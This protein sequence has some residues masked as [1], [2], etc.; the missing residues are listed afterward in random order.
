[1]SEKKVFIV[2]EDVLDDKDL[3]KYVKSLESSVMSVVFGKTGQDDLKLLTDHEL[4]KKKLPD[5]RCVWGNNGNTRDSKL[6]KGAG[7]PNIYLNKEHLE[8]RSSD[9]V[10]DTLRI[11]HNELFYDNGLEK[12]EVLPIVRKLDRPIYKPN[13]TIDGPALVEMGS[14]VSI[15]IFSIHDFKGVKSR[16]KP[17]S[18]GG[19]SI[20]LGYYEYKEFIDTVL[21]MEDKSIKDLSNEIE[22]YNQIVYSYHLWRSGVDPVAFGASEL[23]D[24]LKLDEF[25]FVPSWE[26][27]R[28][29]NIQC[30]PGDMV[31]FLG[32]IPWH[33]E[34][35]STTTPFSGLYLTT[36]EA[37]N[38]WY[39]SDSRQEIINGL[40]TGVVGKNSARGAE[41]N[42]D[43][44]NMIGKYVSPINKMTENQRLFYGIDKYTAIP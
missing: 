2:S 22:R 5:P 24:E 20:L 18:R 42:E 44:R 10:I 25:D 40:Q 32:D 6:P 17:Q 8:I 21:K 16:V 29:H 26:G 23:P 3:P 38:G 15:L 36:T 4:R 13:G 37:C 43:E 14:V 34:K 33:L 30:K 31:S 35:N 28:W 39:N 41:S 27:L 11:V 9:K 1:M 12:E 19:P 7:T